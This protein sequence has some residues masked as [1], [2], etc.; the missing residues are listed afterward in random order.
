[1]ASLK[2]MTF[3]QLV[4]SKSDYLKKEDVGIG[5]A[6]TIRGFKREMIE[7]DHGDEEKTIMGFVEPGYKPMILNRTNA[8]LLAVATGTN[9]VGEAIGKKIWVF[10]D[11]TIPFGGKVVG[12]LRIDKIDRHVATTGAAPIASEP[13]WD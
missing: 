10:N 3:D 13:D 8:S 2:D 5:V 12:G 7:G 9:N 11:P 4:P 6:L 1:M